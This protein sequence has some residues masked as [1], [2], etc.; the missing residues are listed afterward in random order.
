MTFSDL[1]ESMLEDQGYACD[2]MTSGTESVMAGW[3]ADQAKIEVLK[4]NT[5]L[6]EVCKKA[7]QGYRNLVEVQALP[8]EE[9]DKETIKL[10]EQIEAAIAENTQEA[11]S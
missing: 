6:V 8:H 10:A 7:A 9:W 4:R 5:Q 11:N 1:L 3:R 2:E